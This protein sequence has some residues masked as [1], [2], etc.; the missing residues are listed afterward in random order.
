LFV[1]GDV[2]HGSI[3]RVASA[4]GEGSMAIATRTQL[5][6]GSRRRTTV[7]VKDNV[8]F[9]WQRLR[10]RSSTCPHVEEIEPVSPPRPVEGC[11]ACLEVGDT[12]VHL[13]MCMTCGQVGC[14]DSSKNRHA[15]RHAD[16]AGHPVL[17][18]IEPGEDWLWCVIDRRVVEPSR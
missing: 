15:S 9:A 5:P 2:R 3:K 18:S 1:A 12:W 14:C 13:R 17:R 16:A 10:R 4:V 7:S 11:P 8:R 6:H